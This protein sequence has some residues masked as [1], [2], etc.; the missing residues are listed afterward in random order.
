MRHFGTFDVKVRF[1]AT[2]AEQDAQL[3]AWGLTAQPLI[4]AV[5]WAGSFYTQCTSLHPRG[6]RFVHSYAEAGRRVR[7]LHVTR[8]WDIC[9]LNNQTAIRNEA[10]KLRLYPCNFDDATADPTRTP[11]NLT[12]KGYAAESDTRANNQGNLFSD[13]LPH[14]VP[15]AEVERV[16]GYT[17][18]ILGMNFEGEFPKAEIALPVRFMDGTFRAFGTRVPLL[19]GQ[20]APISPV[21]KQKTDDAFGVVEIPIRLVS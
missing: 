16:R 10:L 18:L 19:D 1:A 14:V 15:R 5:L 17:T 3:R 9:D 21:P 7:E 13:A 4:E 6:F 8:G 11:K 20:S 2:P 12:E